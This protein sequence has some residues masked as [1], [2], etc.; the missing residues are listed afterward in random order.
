[1]IIPTCYSYPSDISKQCILNTGVIASTYTVM[2]NLD[3]TTR[4]RLI[5]QW[6]SDPYDE[7]GNNNW[8]LF[9]AMVECGLKE[10][11]G[12]WNFPTVEKEP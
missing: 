6:K 2:G 9:S 1:M 5:E 4:K 7:T 10:F 3:D 8:L 12:E 11:S